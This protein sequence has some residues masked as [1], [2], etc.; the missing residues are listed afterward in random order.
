MSQF[1]MLLL[2]HLLM[3]ASSFAAITVL[4]VVDVRLALASMLLNFANRQ[5]DMMNMITLI[6]Y[7]AVLYIL[8]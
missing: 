3:S 7:A 4:Q 6:E 1:T 8:R 2:Q 5:Q